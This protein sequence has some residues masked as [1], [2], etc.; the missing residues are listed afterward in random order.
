MRGKYAAA[1]AAIR[2]DESTSS[3][4]QEGW[5][6]TAYLEEVNPWQAQVLRSDLAAKKLGLHEGLWKILRD[7]TRELIVHVPVQMDDGTLEIFTGFRVQAHREA[8]RFAGR[9]ARG[10]Q[11]ACHPSVHIFRGRAAITNH[12]RINLFRAV[13]ALLKA[14][15]MRSAV[16]LQHAY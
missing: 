3:S 7:P 11:M 6:T 9:L 16:S 12:L 8:P 2:I 10:E 15:G 4:V 13:A 5:M 14:D 1:F